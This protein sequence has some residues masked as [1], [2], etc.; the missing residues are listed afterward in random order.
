MAQSVA[1]IVEDTEANRTFFER[2]LVQ[3]K[4]E[5]VSAARG[6]EALE[7]MEELKELA[8]ALVDMEI[9]DMS[10][11]LLTSQIRRRHPNCCIVIA[12]MHDEPALMESAFSKGCNVF[13]VKP[14]GFMDLFKKLTTIGPERMCGEGPVI[15]DHYGPRSFK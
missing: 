7:I 12:T 2:L 10:G 1:L 11:L 14:H 3:A 9:P 4:F 15:I 13:L 6:R 5:V 8:L